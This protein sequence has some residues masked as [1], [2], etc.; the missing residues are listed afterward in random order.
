L[1]R[2]ISAAEWNSFRVLWKNVKCERQN[3]QSNAAFRQ[4]QV[5]LSFKLALRQKFWLKILT[6]CTYVLSHKTLL[7]ANAIFNAKKKQNSIAKPVRPVFLKKPVRAYARSWR[8]RAT[9]RRRQLFRR[10]ENL[11]KKLASEALRFRSR[12]APGNNVSCPGANPATLS[13]IQRQRCKNL[14]RYAT[15]SNNK[16]YVLISRKNTPGPNP[17]V[18]ITAL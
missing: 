4:P 2:S 12:F 11:F 6:L 7:K 15:F 18:T 1:N 5:F 16:K 17:W 9:L 14:Q 10:R 3:Q 8:L 13:Y